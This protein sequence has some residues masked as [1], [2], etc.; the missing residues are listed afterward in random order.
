MEW[1]N[2]GSGNSGS[3]CDNH[4]QVDETPADGSNGHECDGG[5]GGGED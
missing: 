4:I 5:D 1:V 2:H 3:E